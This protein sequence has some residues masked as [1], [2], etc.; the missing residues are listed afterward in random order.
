MKL[1]KPIFPGLRRRYSSVDQVQRNPNADIEKH[2]QMRVGQAGNDMI[3]QPMV[4]NISLKNK[5][6][7]KEYIR[8]QTDLSYKMQQLKSFQQQPG[9]SQTNQ[10][11]T[12][13]SLPK[14]V[15]DIGSVSYNGSVPDSRSSASQ[16]QLE[17]KPYTS[18]HDP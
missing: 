5:V 14:Q 10:L 2:V 8:L 13:N 3:L 15:S 6:H 11:D 12:I 1:D 9:K 17:I 4:N 16:K 18:L 7:N